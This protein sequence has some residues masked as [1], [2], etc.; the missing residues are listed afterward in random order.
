[1]H[2]H[3]SVHPGGAEAYA[4]ELY[5]ALRDSADFEPLLVARMGSVPNTTRRGHPGAPFS[6]VSPDDPN[7]FFLYTDWEAYDWFRMTSRDKRLYATYLTDFL[8][9][10]QPDIVH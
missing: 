4:Y 6:A 3:P 2:N 1:M 7:Q 8:K 5:E 10:H 9:L